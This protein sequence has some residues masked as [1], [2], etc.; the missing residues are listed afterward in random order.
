MKTIGSNA[1]LKCSS[2]SHV[3]FGDSLKTLGS[4]AFS[5][6]TFLDASGNVVSHTAAA[7]RGNEYAGADLQLSQVVA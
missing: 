6:I 4:N 7:L 2:L 1:F 3:T 5:G